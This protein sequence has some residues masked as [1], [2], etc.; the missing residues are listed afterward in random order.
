MD[1]TTV[2]IDLAKNDFELAIAGP[3]G[4]PIERRR[5]ARGAFSRFF[6]NRP[7]CHIVMEACGSAHHWGRVFTALGHTVR[8]LPAQYVKAYVR[9]NKTD[10]ADASALLEAQRSQDIQAVPIKT[11][12]QQTILQLHRVR[13]QWMR[14]R[15]ARINSLRG[16]LR[17]FGMAIPVGL[18]PVSRACVSISRSPTARSRLRCAP[19]FTICSARSQSSMR[20][21]R[22]AS[23]SSPR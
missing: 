1:A 7:P 11:E 14:T 21:C 16:C 8:L 23:D 17:E 2:A 13:S 19:S 4:R 22:P 15:T 6:V 10:R 12:A 5:L 9:R 18:A 3:D 20:A